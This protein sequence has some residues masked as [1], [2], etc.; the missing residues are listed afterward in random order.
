MTISYVREILTPKLYD[1][2]LTPY[3]KG[4]VTGVVNGT[5]EICFLFGRLYCKDVNFIHKILTVKE[6]QKAMDK[7]EEYRRNLLEM[8]CQE[9]QVPCDHTLCAICLLTNPRR[10]RQ[11]RKPKVQVCDVCGNPVCLKHK[12]TLSKDNGQH[13][14]MCFACK[15]D[16]D[17]DSIDI[18]SS[19]LHDMVVRWITS[20]D[21]MVIQLSFCI[22]EICSDVADKLSSLQANG[23]K[24]KIG[25]SAASFVSGG[26][27][28]AGTL[29]LLTP[30]GVPLLGKKVFS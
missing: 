8:E 11:L 27:A 5:T 4:V 18:H 6:Y 22:N 17:F 19:N 7:L 15:K 16:F 1:R 20:Y 9:K 14:V 28:V 23:S 10:R 21:R 29:T 3:G 13:F 30:A 12:D 25:A 2:V 26:L 24:V